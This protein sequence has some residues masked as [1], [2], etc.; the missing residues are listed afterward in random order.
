HLVTL[1]S[2]FRCN[3]LVD[4]GPLLPPLNALRVRRACRRGASPISG[5]TRRRV[6]RHPIQGR[7]GH[8]ASLLLREERIGVAEAKATADERRARIIVRPRYTCLLVRD[9]AEVGILDL[10]RR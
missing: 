3:P 8:A 10:F 5:T 4:R 7:I 9:H 2:E 1:P 6:L